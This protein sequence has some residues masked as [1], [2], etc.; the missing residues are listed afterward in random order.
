LLNL[1]IV[2]YWKGEYER[3]H[4]LAEQ[5]A[6]IHREL[7]DRMGLA[8][9]L[10]QLGMTAYQQGDHG[11]AM[12]LM[13]ESL[14]LFRALDEKIGM[15]MVYNDLGIV[16]QANG[17][18]RQAAQLQRD[19]LELAMQ[20]GDVRRAVFC[21]EA[22]AAI[23]GPA[24]PLRAARLFGAAE[25]LRESLGTPLPSAELANYERSVVV[26]QANAS[27]TDFSMAWEAG[28]LCSAEQI[29]HEVLGWQEHTA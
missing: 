10:D 5:A 17:D 15:A 4:A 23:I 2:A 25:A 6:I 29:L 16:A 12:A 11:P 22:L 8:Y 26:A 19:G 3:A 21:I 7:H 20:I 13:A 9:A 14:A 24:D 28:R 18:R 27:A 1:S